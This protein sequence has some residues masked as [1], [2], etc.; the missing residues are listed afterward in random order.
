MKIFGR[1]FVFAGVI[2][3]LAVGGLTALQASGYFPANPWVAGMMVWAFAFLALVPALSWAMYKTAEYERAQKPGQEKLA[4]IQEE[5]LSHVSHEFRSPLATII[6][7]LDLLNRPSEV[8]SPRHADYIKT[9][10]LS[11]QRLKAFVDNVI[12]MSKL[13]AGVMEY[14]PEPVAARDL[15]EAVADAFR[16]QAEA[17][18]I[19]VKV[20]CS[21]QLC[22]QADGD[23]VKKI[24][25][26]V[27]TNALN[28][29]P[30][31]GQITLWAKDSNATSL[32]M[33]I[34]DTG[35]GIP[36]T[37]F[38]RVFEKFEQVKETKDKVRKTL[39]TGLGLTVARRLVELQGGRIW[40]QSSSK[41]G[42]T[43]TWVL[44]KPS[45]RAAPVDRAITRDQLAA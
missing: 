18:H 35:I 31:K 15:L 44:P 29:T 5:F 37:M 26:H 8:L 33:G 39:G 34:T 25:N 42:S 24:L 43:I 11:A 14:E 6:G 7:Y 3:A 4:E 38:E 13:D 20:Q 40:V 2:L 1:A 19:T 30:E 45:R 41:K 23:L 36:R 17:C 21:A 10:R 28:F 12:D 27:L 16:P 22:F 32:L 9:M